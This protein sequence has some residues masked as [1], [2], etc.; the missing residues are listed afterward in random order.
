MNF[1]SDYVL[2]KKVSPKPGSSLLDEIEPDTNVIS[3]RFDH[4]VNCSNAYAGDPYKCNNCEALISNISK[5]IDSHSIDKKKSWKC[6]FCNFENRIM[7]ENDEIPKNEEVTY[8]LETPSEKI[9]NMEDSSVDNK[10]L[11]Y[12]IDISGSMSVTTE[13]PGNL[14]LPTDQ[15]R[16]ESLMHATGERVPY[17]RVK[18]I[19]RLEALQVA[20]E[21]N[22]KNLEKH[23]PEKR[24]GLIAFNQ[25]VSIIGDGQMNVTK[26]DDS[27]ID[28]KEEIKKIAERT[29]SFQTILKNKNNLSRKL[30]KYLLH[31]NELFKLRIIKFF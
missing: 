21:D 25:H 28:D 17:N 26:L 12:C 4:L 22:L 27:C 24:V 2:T 3:T 1:A 16:R 7:I 19:S 31:L 20:I 30:I 18:H 29:P 9:D 14:V 15:A 10:Y 13:V 23:N 8:I 6:E 11:I 5:V